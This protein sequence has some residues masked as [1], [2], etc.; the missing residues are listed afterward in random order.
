MRIINCLLCHQHVQNVLP[1]FNYNFLSFILGVLSNPNIKYPIFFSFNIFSLNQALT[2]NWKLNNNSKNNKRLFF[3]FF[4][5]KQ[6]T[7]YLVPN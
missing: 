7:K 4:F 6:T 2:N 3:F 1:L 5:E